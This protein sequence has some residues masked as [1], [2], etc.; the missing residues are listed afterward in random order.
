MAV[1]PGRHLERLFSFTGD[2]GGAFV[3][4]LGMDEDFTSRFGSHM[5]SRKYLNIIGQFSDQYGWS[6]SGN[7][8]LIMIEVPLWL[9]DP[10]EM[11]RTWDEFS[12]RQDWRN[13]LFS[14][15]VPI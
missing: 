5:E 9:S 7:D 6:L 3:A 11:D 4:A 2:I 14:G 1:T 8:K 10:E 12:P 15:S 13:S